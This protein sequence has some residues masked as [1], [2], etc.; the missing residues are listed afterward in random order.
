MNKYKERAGKLGI[1]VIYA[2]LSTISL[3][4][5]WL[6]G[7]IYS[8]GLTGLVQL[9]VSLF[10]KFGFSAPSIAVLV[11]VL[12][13]PLLVLAW[14]KI[15]REFT[16]FTIVAVALMSL[17]LGGI[18][19]VPLTTDPI[20]CSIFGAV[21]HGLAIGITLNADF[22]TG[23]L[24]IIGIVVRMK[25]GKSIG[26]IFII[27]NLV[28]E[29]IAGFVFGWRYA[30]YSAIAVFLNGLVVDYVNTKQQKVQVLIVT[31]EAP[32]MIQELQATIPRGITVINDAEGAFSHEKRKILLAVVARCELK[33]VNELVAQIDAQAFTSVA[34]GIET[35]RALTEW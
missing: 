15:D 2:L 11:F 20:I 8:N 22:S 34:K 25:T 31:E 13:I 18:P 6:P 26:T 4:F 19:V 21:F 24:D 33:T 9:I 29:F 30:F 23:G 27:F 28:I 3:N 5:F 16:V 14:F 35:N 1:A 7:G 12:N 32:K 17:F 10:D